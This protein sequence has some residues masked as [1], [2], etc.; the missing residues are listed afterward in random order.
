[1][2]AAR[3]RQ[4]PL[5]PEL[6]QHATTC[7]NLQHVIHLVPFP[8]PLPQA[9]PIH[10]WDACGGDLRCTYRGYNDVDEVTAAFSV[11]FSPDGRKVLGGYSKSIAVF[12]VS[13]PGRDYTKVT[14][15]S[16][17]KS[18]GLPGVS[19]PERVMTCQVRLRGPLKE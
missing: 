14:T 17:K 12:D 4:P 9:H 3:G 5:Q 13:R 6:Q 2:G 11:C 1:M 16:K 7:N 19:P 10:L 15:W 18:N 8:S